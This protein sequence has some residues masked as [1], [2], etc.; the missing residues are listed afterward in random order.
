MHLAPLVMEV[1]VVAVEGETEVAE[2]VVDKE[3]KGGS[4]ALVL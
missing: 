1:E 2:E 4:V 3:S